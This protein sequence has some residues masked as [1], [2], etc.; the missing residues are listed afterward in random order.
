[1]Y[2]LY[3]MDIEQTLSDTD[4]QSIDPKT[5]AKMS[6]IFNA[7]NDGWTIRKKK[8]K[9]V[10]VKPHGNHKEVFETSYLDAFIKKNLYIHKK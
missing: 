7:V 1:M 3:I 5:F 4:M 10:F 9:Y 8:D 6:F 2:S